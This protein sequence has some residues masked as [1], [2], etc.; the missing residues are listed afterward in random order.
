MDALG[1]SLRRGGGGGGEEITDGKVL[2]DFLI[3]STEPTPPPPPTP[4]ALIADA[5]P[6]KEAEVVRITE[7]HEPLPD[8]TPVLFTAV[9]WAAEVQA[10]ENELPP[11]APATPVPVV[12]P[13]PPVAVVRMTRTYTFCL[14]PSILQNWQQSQIDAVKAGDDPSKYGEVDRTSNGLLRVLRDDCR[15]IWVPN[16]PTL[17]NALF[18]AVHAAFNGGA[19]RGV[20]AMMTIFSDWVYW[21]KSRRFVTRRVKECPTC[22]VCRAPNGKTHGLAQPHDVPVALDS[23]SPWTTSDRSNPTR[24]TA[25]T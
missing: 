15:K 23:S 1:S 20:H 10:A 17:Y 8:G 9:P 18:D 5:D 14:D 21:P 12:T 7:Y 16:S 13:L 6:P 22:Q 11:N 25:A 19:H 4:L 2:E 3:S 24:T